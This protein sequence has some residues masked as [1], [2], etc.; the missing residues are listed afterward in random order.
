MIHGRS[1]CAE[2]GH[3]VGGENAHAAARF[4]ANQFMMHRVAAGAS[5][6]DA[7]PHVHV[8]LVKRDQPRRFERPEISRQIARPVAFVRMGRILPLALPH[9]MHGVR[10]RRDRDA[11]DQFRQTADVVEVQMRTNDGR[12][13]AGRHAM[14]GQ[15][16]LDARLPVDAVDL[17]FL[18]AHLARRRRRR[19]G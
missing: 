14:R 16:A 17:D 9:V 15:R 13:I 19:S 11:V 8:V 4:D 5:R 1:T 3:Q 10:K 18:G 12:H 2:V 6:A 7:R